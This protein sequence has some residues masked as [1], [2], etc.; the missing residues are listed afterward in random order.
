VQQ[1]SAI[2]I[3]KNNLKILSLDKSITSSSWRRCLREAY[4]I[5]ETDY[6]NCLELIH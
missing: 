3:H 2:L 6:F 5:S 4:S 1:H